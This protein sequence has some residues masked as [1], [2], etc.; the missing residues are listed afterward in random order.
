VSL[1]DAL[2]HVFG[3]PAGALV[4]PGDIQHRA[5]AYNRGSWNG[6]SSSCEHYVSRYLGREDVFHAACEASS[7]LSPSV[8]DP[9]LMMWDVVLAA[10]PYRHEVFAVELEPPHALWF[11]DETGWSV[12]APSLFEG[13]HPWPEI[14]ATEARRRRASWVVRLLPDYEDFLD[15]AERRVRSSSTPEM[16]ASMRTKMATEGWQREGRPDFQRMLEAFAGSPRRCGDALGALWGCFFLEA[17]P[18]LAVLSDEL[19]EHSSA[20]VRSAARLAVNAQRGQAGRFG[21]VVREQRERFLDALTR[22]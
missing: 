6:D 21:Q 7:W 13:S 22:P 17:G 18:A 15:E 5:L 4:S 14:E 2:Q 12:R 19:A 9:Y 16:L 8:A 20:A 10:V 11:R 3:R 1:A